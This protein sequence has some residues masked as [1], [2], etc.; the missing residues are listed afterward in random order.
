[1]ARAARA[2]TRTISTEQEDGWLL[3]RL[4]VSGQ[5]ASFGASLDDLK[6]LLPDARQQLEGQKLA[7]GAAEAPENFDAGSQAAVERAIDEAFVSGYLVVMLVAT[8]LA[9][10]LG[11]ALPIEGRTQDEEIEA[12]KTKILAA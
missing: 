3:K 8:A 9:S 7:L 5:F 11:A 4:A 2:R 6:Y 10:A 1:L 12:P